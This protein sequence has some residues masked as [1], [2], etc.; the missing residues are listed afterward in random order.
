ME[1]VPLSFCSAFQQTEAA[2]DLFCKIQEDGKIMKLK[3][4]LKVVAV[5]GCAGALAVSFA[6][7][8]GGEEEK[9]EGKTHNPETLEVTGSAGIYEPHNFVD[10]KCTMCDETTIFTQDSIAKDA[11]VST[12]CDQQGTVTEI[13]YTTDA[14]PDWEYADN[15]I[16]TKTA[17]VYTPYGYDPEDTATK[18]NV[19]ILMH[20]KGLNEGYWFAKGTYADPSQ[21]GAYLSG[22]NGTANVLDTMMKSG[23]AEKA[24]VV[25][26]TVYLPGADGKTANANSEEGDANMAAGRAGFQDELLNDLMPYIAKNYNTYAAVTNDMSA[27]QVDS[28]L[29]A[30][31]EHQGY[32]GLSM[33]SVVSYTTIWSGC[34]EYFAYIGSYS[35]GV[36]AEE[37][38]AL[39]EAISDFEDC[40][41]G[42]WYAC[43]G[44]SETPATYYGDPF[45]T[46]LKVL[47]NFEG[48]Q[49]GSDLDAGDNCQYMLCNGTAHNYQTWITA[50]YNSLQVFFKADLS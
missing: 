39:V 28:A 20:G 50:L 41:I 37:M 3:N 18:Y 19:L 8:G 7:C 34:L 36:T 14:Y 29:K 33:G 48:L 35:G 16:V 15:G 44:S 21:Q 5:L 38:P 17:W 40:K 49:P 11:I 30:A 45:G 6:A 13:K 12:A 2:A 47:Q 25:T 4:M 31:R 24:I 46:Y 32:A 9:P 26:P 22:G 23:A 43:L 1:F 42:Y 10:G 27:E